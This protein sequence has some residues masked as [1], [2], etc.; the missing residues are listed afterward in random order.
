[1]DD[2]RARVRELVSELSGAPAT[3]DAPL[4]LDSLTIVTLI[5]ALEDAFDVRFA[6]R[7]ANE[8][9]FRSVAALAALVDEKRGAP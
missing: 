1:M 4:E 3:D 9:N 5:E 2:T 8:D 7:D 6:A